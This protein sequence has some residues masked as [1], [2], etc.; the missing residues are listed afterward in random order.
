MNLGRCLK[1]FFYIQLW[2]PL[3]SVDWNQQSR[4]VSAILV[5]GI[6]GNTCGIVLN[7]DQQVRRHF[8]CVDV[9]CPSQ[10]FFSHDKVF[11]CYEPVL[12]CK[13]R[14]QCLAQSYN[15]RLC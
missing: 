12:Q 11:S 4:T 14:V 7:L 1:L 15:E 8:V 13:L 6:V 9:L 3:C 5:V 2:Q 10:Q